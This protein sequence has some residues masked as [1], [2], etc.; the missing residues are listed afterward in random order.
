VSLE[1]TR[2]EQLFADDLTIGQ[3]FGGEPRAVGDDAF[4]AFA[5]TTG[6]DHP[7]H[8]DD[9]Y[10]AK[11]RFGKRLAHGLLVMSM[12]AFGATKMS[13]SFED[14]MVAFIGQ[15]AKFLK[16]V[17]V[18]D[19]LTSGFKVVSVERKVGRDIALVQFDVSLVNGDGDVVLE[20]H[21]IY[22][23]QCRAAADGLLGQS[24]A[25]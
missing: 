10:A 17:F 1:V 11:T 18:G 25:G 6:D 7:I 24:H 2:L 22:L 14:S 19:V 4:K 8:Y 3:T 20:G 15:G 13:H 23:L 16:P 12:T 21:H 9:A 5:D